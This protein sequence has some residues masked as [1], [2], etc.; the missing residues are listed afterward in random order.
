MEDI[1]DVDCA[2][3]KR[4]CKDFEINNLGQYHDLYVQS[5][6]LLLANVFQNFRNMCLK[7]LLMVGRGTR[8]AICHFAKANNKYMKDYNKN[9]ELSYIQY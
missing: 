7:M 1:T 4:D 3:I 8:G 9:K 5:N 2:H 6:T